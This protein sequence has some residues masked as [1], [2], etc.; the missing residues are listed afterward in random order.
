[1]ADVV[2]V[3]RDAVAGQ[4]GGVQRRGGRVSR[5]E[6]RAAL[7]GPGAPGRDQGAAA[8]GGRRHRDIPPGEARRAAAGL[9]RRR[10]AVPARVPHG[11]APETD[12]LSELNEG[13]SLIHEDHA[14][15][16]GNI[17]SILKL[18]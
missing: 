15:T 13:V 9:D 8:D 16:A 1:A 6:V 14:F 12:P 18:P 4:T 2:C 5:R 10:A 7:D 11:P 17:L 3:V